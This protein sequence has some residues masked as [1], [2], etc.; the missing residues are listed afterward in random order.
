MT[1]VELAKQM[2][3]IIEQAVSIALDDSAALRSVPLFPKWASGLAVKKTERYQYNGVLYRVA[4]DHTTQ[5]EWTPDK[6]P[7]L[8]VA[9]SADPEQGTADNP[10]TAVRGMEY[11]Y[12]LYYKDGDKVYLCKRTGEAEGGTIVLQYL[13]HELVGQYFV[14]MQ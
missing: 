6:T 13:P 1:L 11:T 7:A 5:P 8:W 4:Q 3:P 12:G 2:R 10:I 14:E 9:V